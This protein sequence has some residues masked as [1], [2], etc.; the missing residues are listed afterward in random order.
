MIPNADQALFELL[1]K[2][3]E[4]KSEFT[5]ANKKFEK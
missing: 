1:E 5:R 2:N 4:R 3:P